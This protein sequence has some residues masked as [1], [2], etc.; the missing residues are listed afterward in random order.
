MTKTYVEIFY[1]GSLFPESKVRE[2]KDR[3][4]IDL[5]SGAFA[6]SFFDQEETIVK[7]E[8][9]VGKQKNRSGRFYAGELFTLAEVKEKFPESRILISNMENNGYA[10]VV[11]TVRGNFQPFMPEDTMLVG[12]CL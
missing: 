5:P 10:K 9:L 8:I 7:G 6:F 1:P 11:K 12:A 4:P 3:T 2:V